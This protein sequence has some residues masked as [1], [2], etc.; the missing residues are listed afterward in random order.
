MLILVA[1]NEGK[2]LIMWTLGH[3]QITQS[4]LYANNCKLDIIS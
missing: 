3:L 2:V 1:T 4:R